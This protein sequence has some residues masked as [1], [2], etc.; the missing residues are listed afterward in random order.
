VAR[1]GEPVA[2]APEAITAMRQSRAVVEEVLSKGEPVYSLNTGVGE[3]KAFALDPAQRQRFN[4]RLVLNHRIAQ[5]SVAPA[6]VVRGAMVCLTN[7]YAKG[8][9]RATW[10]RWPTSRT[11]C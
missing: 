5:G 7:S 1:H 4:Q 3:R 8:V 9:A 6:E 2:L 10:A 11:A